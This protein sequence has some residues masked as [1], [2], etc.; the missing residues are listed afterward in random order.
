M[1]RTAQR[2]FRIGFYFDLYSLRVADWATEIRYNRALSPEVLEIL[3]E[4]PGSVRSL[5]GARAKWLARELADIPL[6]V[7]APTLSV[8]FCASLRS[9]RRA[10]L[11]EHLDTL[12]FAHAVG[13]TEI[14]IHGGDYS[15]ILEANQT[16]ATEM[17]VEAVAP[18]VD[19]ARQ[20]G[21]VLCLE[22]LK[23]AKVFPVTEAQFEVALRTYPLMQLA[24]DI[25]HAAIEGVPVEACVKR[26]LPRISSFHYRN[27]APISAE[28]RLAWIRGLVEDGWRGDLIIEDPALNRADKS[29][30]HVIAAGVRSILA[31]LAEVTSADP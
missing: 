17:F 15:Y 13:A 31:T 20:R 26:Y 6:R 3:I 5:C 2:G 4:P 22:N 14:T 9:V 19:A 12:D 8:S 29:D 16:S 24:F 28:T 1:N 10:T 23:G 25:R 27:D 11:R 21:L 18:L 7:H 30:K